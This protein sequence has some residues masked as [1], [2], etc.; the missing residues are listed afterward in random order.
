MTIRAECKKT[1]PNPHGYD[2]GEPYKRG[3]WWASQCVR[4]KITK[5]QVWFCCP[6]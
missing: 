5:A 1:K 2:H 6:D 4:Y 3:Y